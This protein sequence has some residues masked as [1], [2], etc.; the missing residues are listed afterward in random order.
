[1]I[2]IKAERLVLRRLTADDAEN[3]YLLNLDPEVIRYTGDHSFLNI[4][5][6]KHFL[7]SYTHYHEYGFGRWAVM[8]KNSHEFL[9]WCGLKYSPEKEETDIGFRFFKKHW[10]KGYATEAARASLEIGFRQYKI[11]EIVGR[12]MKANS[13]SVSILE[14]LGLTFKKKVDFGGH[15][16][17]SYS[18]KNPLSRKE[19]SS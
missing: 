11:S 1:M 10:G 8:D 7:D 15:E 4:E 14:K 3:F 2:V 6:A 16:G 9:G 12:A 5:E 18:V 19:A 17:V 13:A